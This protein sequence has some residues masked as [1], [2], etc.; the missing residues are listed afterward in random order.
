VEYAKE[1]TE[2]LLIQVTVHNR[3]PDAAELQVLPTL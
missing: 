3:G 2:D 1:S